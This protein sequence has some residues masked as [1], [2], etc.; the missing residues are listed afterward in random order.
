MGMA[1]TFI[2]E[3]AT[4]KGGD[5]FTRGCFSTMQTGRVERELGSVV[6]V[7]E[8]R[9]CSSGAS[10]QVDCCIGMKKQKNKNISQYRQYKVMK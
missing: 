3:R 4:E 2:I 1:T 5:F 6:N 9:M 10:T 8:L 7:R